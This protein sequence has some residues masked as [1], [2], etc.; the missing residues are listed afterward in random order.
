MTSPAEPASTPDDVPVPEAAPGPGVSE[1]DIRDLAAQLMAPPLSFDPSTIRKG[2]VTAVSAGDASNAP[3]I[4][5][6]L[7]GDDST[8]ID[9]VRLAADYSPNIGDTT[10]L[11]KQGASLFAAF[12]IAEAGSITA[13]SSVGGWQ[14]ANLLTGM[15]HNGNSQ[16]NLMFRRVLEDGSWKVQWKGGVS[17]SGTQTAICT[18]DGDYRPSGLRSLVAARDANGSNVVKVDF[19]PSGSVS[20]V[21][22]T[23]RADSTQLADSTH[24]HSGS[25]NGGDYTSSAGSHS[26]SYSNYT[27]G[28]YST[29]G[30]G[31]HQ[32]YAYAQGISES[33]HSHGSHSHAVASPAWVSL[34]GLEYFL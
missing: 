11:I 13:S 5:V 34:N 7:S 26:H 15:A 27:L 18:V 31:S 19:N 28:T 12:K 6:T 22:P 32:H 24:S 17:I 2:V 10:I 3:T 4:S 16:G 9:G 21:G 20:I 25:T 8:V 14:Q 30:G 29:S 23:T 1:G 33:T